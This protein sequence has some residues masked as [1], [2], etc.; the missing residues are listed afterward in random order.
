MSFKLLT[1]GYQE[2]TDNPQLELDCHRS[3]DISHSAKKE[4]IH[5][6]LGLTRRK[7]R[8]VAWPR[9]CNTEAT[10]CSTAPNA[11]H[12]R[13]ANIASLATCWRSYSKIAMAETQGFNRNTVE[14]SSSNTKTVDA[15][16]SGRNR[17]MEGKYDRSVSHGVEVQVA[18]AAAVIVVAQGRSLNTGEKYNH[19]ASHLRTAVTLNAATRRKN[20]NTRSKCGCA[21]PEGYSSTIIISF[22]KG[23]WM[24]SPCP[25]SIE[26]GAV[27]EFC[28]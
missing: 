22:G 20:H 28:A 24:A 4:G 9:S 15:I 16:A 14:E 1:H 12:S 17:S 8:R 2:I 5:P 10:C 3:D 19:V 25:T 7:T 6:R 21:R 11:P 13:A 18:N 27:E 26:T 23:V